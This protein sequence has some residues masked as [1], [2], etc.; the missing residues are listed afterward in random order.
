MEYDSY[1]QNIDF[2]YFPIE[3]KKV[4]HKTTNRLFNQ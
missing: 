1:P 3:Y 2:E 4:F